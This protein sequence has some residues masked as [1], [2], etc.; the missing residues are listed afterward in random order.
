MIHAGEN[1]VAID[2]LRWLLNDCSEMI[3]AHF[4]LGKLAVEIDNDLP[5]ARAHFGFGYSAGARAL[6]RAGEPGPLP[7]LHPANRYFFDSGRGLAWVLHG[8]QKP[9]MAIEVIEHL[10]QCDPSDPLQVGGWIDEMRT[11]GL[12]VIEL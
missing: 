3:E 8:L 11:G 12:P 2:E 6:K 7:A 4:L 1:D 5:L 10:L 9:S